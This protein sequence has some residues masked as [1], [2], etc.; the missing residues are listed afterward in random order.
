MTHPSSLLRCSNLRPLPLRQPA[1][2]LVVG[3]RDQLAQI[4]RRHA[5]HIDDGHPV[6]AG[7][8]A[9]GLDALHR[10]QLQE[11]PR[12]DPHA[13]PPALGL[14]GLEIGEGVAA[15]LIAQHVH[16]RR[17]QFRGRTGEAAA[18]CFD[19]GGVHARDGSGLAMRA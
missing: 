12:I 4:R 2:G 7:H 3:P 8:V 15:D 19:G 17:M 6:E 5:A 14:A 10:G 11:A 13:E 18:V 1:Q 16:R 9:R